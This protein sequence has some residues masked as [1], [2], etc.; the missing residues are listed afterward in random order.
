LADKGILRLREQL[1]F[2]DAGYWLRYDQNPKKEILFQIDWVEGDV[3]PLIES[4]RLQ[5]PQSGTAT[6]LAFGFDSSWEGRTRISG[7]DWLDE[8]LVD[9]RAVRAFRNGYLVTNEVEFKRGE[10]NVF[11]VVTLPET[12]FS[13][14]FDAPAHQLVLAYRD[15]AAGRFC[16]KT[17]AIHEGDVLSF[18]PL[19]D[20]FLVTKGD[21][22]WKEAVFNI[23]PQDMGWYKGSDYQRFEVEQLKHIAEFTGDW[24]FEQYA[25]RHRHFLEA[26]EG[27]E[28]VVVEDEKLL[29]VFFRLPMPTIVETSPT[30][31]NHGFDAALDENAVN[32]YVAGLENESQAFVILD[33]GKAVRLGK[34]QLEWENRHNFAKS[35]VV[36]E[37]TGVTDTAREIVRVSA[38][39][40]GT[41]TY[42]RL[43]EQGV[44]RII[45]IDFSDFA[46]QPRL[47]LRL[48]TFFGEKYND[49]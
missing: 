5:N 42:V 31:P 36:S 27:G 4:V 40:A 44:V 39:P 7:S 18:V 10:H 6:A 17:Q 30:Y 9:G 11:F 38:E 29:S 46:G 20:G 41:Q 34:I 37:I 2:F 45:K 49:A 22:E 16:L 26:K 21:G 47:L 43:P 12:V 15:V 8:G 28:A 48:M 32:D 13:D 24:F 19:R 3:S 14:Y 25:E 1:H 33:F 35:I 23:R